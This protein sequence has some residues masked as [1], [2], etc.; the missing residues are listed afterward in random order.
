VLLYAISGS[1]CHV[2]LNDQYPCNFIPSCY[3]QIRTCYIYYLS[4]TVL[5]LTTRIDLP[6]LATFHLN[7]WYHGNFNGT[8]K[9]KARLFCMLSLMNVTE[10]LPVSLWLSNPDDPKSPFITY[11]FKVVLFSS[12]SSPFML[13]ATLHST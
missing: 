10:T 11:R 1:R 12:N 5:V 8:C 9:G 6:F 2:E 3:P 4:L 7:V 13:S